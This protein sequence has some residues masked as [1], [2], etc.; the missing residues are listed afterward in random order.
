MRQFSAI[1][2]KFINHGISLTLYVIHDWKAFD[3]RINNMRA[4]RLFRD[5]WK[6]HNF[7]DSALSLYLYRP[8]SKCD[9]IKV[10]WQVI[11]VVTHMFSNHKNGSQPY[12]F[13]SINICLIYWLS[14]QP[15]Y[16]CYQKILIFLNFRSEMVDSTNKNQA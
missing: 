8:I 5:F 3:V 10:H 9:L 6:A 14:N 7:G 2:F 13:I 1:L 15:L 12:S 4:W 16:F 11:V